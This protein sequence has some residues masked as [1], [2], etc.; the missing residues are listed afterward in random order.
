MEFDPC[1]YHAGGSPS[2]FQ[3]LLKSETATS[4][5]ILSDVDSVKIEADIFISANHENRVFLHNHNKR[6][7]LQLLAR[8]TG[9]KALYWA[10]IHMEKYM[11][12]ILNF[13]IES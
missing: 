1:P 6:L 11:L 7:L 2:L 10:Q 3:V 13:K 5:M 4:V 9:T 12:V 8:A